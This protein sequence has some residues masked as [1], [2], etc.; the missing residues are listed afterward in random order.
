MRAYGLDANNSV[1][2]LSSSPR[3][4]N[5]FEDSKERLTLK[6]FKKELSR[7]FE[8]ISKSCASLNPDESHADLISDVFRY[9]DQA[10][11]F[12]SLICGVCRS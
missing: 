5:C 12:L 2:L 8:S 4:I 11:P 1:S 9:V 7:T 3:S 10:V 6:E